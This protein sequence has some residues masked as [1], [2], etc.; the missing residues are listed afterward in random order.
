MKIDVLDLNITVKGNIFDLQNM[1]TN[2]MLEE[3][4]NEIPKLTIILQN[5][6]NLIG[7]FNIQGGEKIEFSVKDENKN[8]QTTQWI[9]DDIITEYN[10]NS[11]DARF[12]HEGLV[13]FIC[14]P[15]WYYANIFNAHMYY[16]VDD[17]L[18]SDKVKDIL[19]TYFGIAENKMDIETDI[20]TKTLLLQENPFESILTLKD[21]A[22]A[23]NNTPYLFLIRNT[24][25]GNDRK[26]VF[27]SFRTLYEEN[28]VA[29]R[30]KLVGFTTS[31]RNVNNTMLRHRNTFVCTT[32][33][34]PKIL[35]IKSRFESN[36]IY[37]RI[38]ALDFDTGKMEFVEL[39]LHDVLDNSKLS[40]KAYDVLDK[41]ITFIP[42]ST[43]DPSKKAIDSFL[44][45]QMEYNKL[46]MNV[47]PKLDINI[48]DIMKIVNVY[49]TRDN[50]LLKDFMISKVK[51]IFTKNEI[52]TELT[53]FGIDIT[54]KNFANL[55]LTYGDVQ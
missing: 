49:N 35:K 50:Y 45:S 31:D 44:K 46:V 15:V 47:V 24:V 12:L 21:Y 5:S 32:S 1:F 7:R 6:N 42:E 25:S 36:N 53:M 23:K 28:S 33:M 8:F 37:K 51:H 22:I 43:T 19:S 41:K 18:C 52:A 30:L 11:L 16:K 2:I 54:F 27:K 48:G 29:N 39:G 20:E 9:I 10:E 26:Y 4:I 17:E 38:Q 34:I 3:E 13:T 14:R 40:E 55:S